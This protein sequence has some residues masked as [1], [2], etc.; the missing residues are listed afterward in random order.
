M[1]HLGEDSNEEVT[2]QDTFCLVLWDV[3]G[4]E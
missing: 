3:L 1:V 2:L 4:H